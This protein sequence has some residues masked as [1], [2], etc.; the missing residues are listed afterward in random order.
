MNQKRSTNT[1]MAFFVLV[2]AIIVGIVSLVTV[3]PPI[4][5]VMS[6]FFPPVE[7]IE[8]INIVSEGDLVG[9]NVT[10]K[11]E[12]IQTL[13]D[14]AGEVS[15]KPEMKSYVGKKYEGTMYHIRMA[16]SGTEYDFYVVSDGSIYH[17]NGKYFMEQGE[18]LNA[19]Y[20]WLEA[21]CTPKK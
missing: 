12:D 4:P 15:M 20:D 18:A 3:R 10:R 13:V 7:Q 21:F 16:Y 17:A 14:L 1:R 5:E 6:E 19:L 2:V 8:Y 11:A 9:Y